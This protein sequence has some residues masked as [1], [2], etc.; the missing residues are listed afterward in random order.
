[1]I[2]TMW[3]AAAGILAAAPAFAGAKGTFAYKGVS[4]TA[5]DAVACESKPEMGDGTAVRVMLASKALDAA[6][7][8]ATLDF[9]QAVQAQRGD[10]TYVDLEFGN[11]GHW[12]GAS[13]HLGGSANCGWCGDS[14]AGAK[15]QVRVEGGRLKG[16]LRVRPADY[17]DHEGPVV[18][19]TLDL[20][21]LR[22]TG[23]TPLGADGGPAGKAL[24]ACRQSVLKKDA[25][26]ARTACF[27]ADDPRLEIVANSSEDGFWMAGF[28]DRESLK[29]PTLKIT[30]GR[31]KGDWAEVLVEGKD[32][33]GQQRKGSVFLR[34]GP[35]GWRYHH[36]NLEYVF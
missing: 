27:A 24:V 35:A 28:Y 36:D 11:D 34:R 10:G 33:S 6:A 12:A 14:A 3:M 25:A 20:P 22:Q 30:G 19:L 8:E 17:S 21:I 13:Y 26:G 9:R 1:V 2:K 23:G 4:F 31:T 7:V 29:I 16:T 5:V 15:S 32:E 18:D